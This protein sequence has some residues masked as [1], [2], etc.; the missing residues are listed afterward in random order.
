MVMMAR[1]FLGW[2]LLCFFFYFLFYFV[3]VFVVVRLLPFSF[4]GAVFGCGVLDEWK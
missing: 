4:V 1:G 2:F 3:A